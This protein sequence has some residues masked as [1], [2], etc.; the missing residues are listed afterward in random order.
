MS[1]TSINDANGVDA[2][3]EPQADARR[4]E[5]Y[6]S[7]DALDEER[8]LRG[9]MKDIFDVGDDPVRVGRFELIRRIGSGATGHVHE[10]FDTGRE[11]RVALKL[12]GAQM[13][14]WPAQ[15]RQ[16]WRH[17]A[18]VLAGLSHPN[19]VRVYEVGV[20]HEPIFISMELVCGK[21]L[22]QWV[23]EDA[24]GWRERLGVLRQAGEGLAVAHEQGIVHHDFKPHNVLLGLRPATSA[25]PAGSPGEGVVERVCVSDFGLARILPAPADSERTG[26][27]GGSEPKSRR[28][29]RGGTLA[30]LAPEQRH[31]A[32]SAHSDQ[33]SF[34]VTAYRALF[35]DYP[36][37][38][39]SDG[40][41]RVDPSAGPI[42]PEDPRGVPLIV[43]EV[44]ER[45]LLAEPGR[46]HPGM[47]ALLAALDAA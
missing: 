21:N 38:R 6:P 30:Y 14:R 42:A 19:I 27:Q 28:F 15:E 1:T 31:G 8:V 9:V 33:F 3:V 34:C 26:P 32:V 43:R 29:V 37:P 10:A 5:P 44:I 18:Q 22:V 16:A 17:E 12:L 40:G 20:E 11:C 13:A 7:I 41:L 4:A 35:G 45:G 36:Y 2:R 46:R 25:E 39:E 23:D 24:P 47:R